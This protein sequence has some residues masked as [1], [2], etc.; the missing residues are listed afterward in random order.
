MRTKGIRLTPV[1][2][3]EVGADAAWT[4]GA[5]AGA[6]GAVVGVVAAVVVR[7]NTPC[8]TAC[9]DVDQ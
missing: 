8:C 3:S 7:P 1:N 6:T 2:G 9:A 4:T 5:A